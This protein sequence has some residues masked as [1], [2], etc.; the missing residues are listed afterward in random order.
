MI[1]SVFSR[2]HPDAAIRTKNPIPTTHRR[3]PI[4]DGFGKG[5]HDPEFD[6]RDVARD[7]SGLNPDAANP[8]VRSCTGLDGFSGAAR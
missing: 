2:K 7:V 4:A 8:I 5:F 3:S 1:G 6:P